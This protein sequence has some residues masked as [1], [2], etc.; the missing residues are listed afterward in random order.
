MLKPLAERA[1]RNL[2]TALAKARKLWGAEGSVQSNGLAPDRAEKERL[3]HEVGA[4]LAGA[5]GSPSAEEKKRLRVIQ[6]RLLQ[7]KF[8]VGI[9][10]RQS[11][12]PLFIIHGSGDSWEEAFA[13]ALKRRG[14]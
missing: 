3:R 9:I 1:V 7:S 8:D 6:G 4:I 12:L 11:P 2:V 13:E 14:A 10:P 5:G